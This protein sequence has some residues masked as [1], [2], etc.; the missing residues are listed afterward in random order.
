MKSLFRKLALTFITLLFLIFTLGPIIWCFIISVSP[1]KE[2]F[3]SSVNLLPQHPTFDNYR[4]LLDF[5]SRQSEIFMRGLFNSIEAVF[6]TLLIGIPVCLMA[7]YALSRFNFKS[8]AFIRTS[9]LITIVIPV[10][11]TI[12]PLYDMFSKA[13]FLDNSFWLSIVYVSSFLPMITWI[14]SNYM[15]TIPRE[16][17]EA[18]FLDGCGRVRVF[19]NIILPNSYPII[20]AVILMVFLLTWSQYQ[21]PMILASSLQTKPLSMIVAEFT[22]KDMIQYGITA[23]AGILALLPPTVVAVIFRKSLI[24]GMAQG[25]VKG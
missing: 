18:A 23:A 24:L 21:I 25:S 4:M 6:I 14:L 16:L 3:S 5:N 15:N 10:F 19:L 1:E 2:M 13:G 12:I 17:D 7:A 9:L 8:K 22:N 11:T 20:F